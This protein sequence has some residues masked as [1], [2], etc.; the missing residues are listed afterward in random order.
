MPSPVPDGDDVVAPG[1]SGDGPGASHPTTPEQVDVGEQVDV[2]IDGEQVDVVHLDDLRRELA[3]LESEAA[4]FEAE[5]KWLE[6]H[7]VKS[8]AAKWLGSGPGGNVPGGGV[9]DLGEV[10]V[11]GN[12]IQNPVKP[13][14]PDTSEVIDSKVRAELD[15]T[16]KHTRA[17]RL[18]G[19]RALPGAEA[20]Q[21]RI[22]R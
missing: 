11:L 20:W 16:K 4:E 12:G 22:W 7:V 21:T 5:A 17:T 8:P 9:G 18:Q 15:M 2:V 1:A 14:D 19:R 13:P 6:A 10:G 3:L